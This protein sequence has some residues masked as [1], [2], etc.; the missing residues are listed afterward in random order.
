MSTKQKVLQLLE[1]NR[2]EALS[3]QEMAETLAVSRTSVWKAIEALRQ[4]GYRIEAGPNKGYLLPEETDILSAEAIRLHLDK[5]NSELALRVYK[6]IDS[7]NA[8]AKRILQEGIEQPMLLV[9]EEQTAGRG[10]LGR[11]F[12]SP[13]SSGLYMSLILPRVEPDSDPGLIT[14]AAAVAV[15]RAIEKTTGK[16]PKIKWVN[17]LFLDQRKICG[18]LSEG[19]I[20]FETQTI[21]S[22]IVGI[23]LN[24]RIEEESMPSEL[25]NIVGG[26]YSRE[27]EEEPAVR[28]QLAAQSMNEF[29]ALYPGDG[30]RGY[31]EEY[32]QRCFVLGRKVS[33]TRNGET[34]R[35]EAL[36]IDEQG[37]LI[38][39]LE[40]GEDLTLTYG[41]ISVRVTE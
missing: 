33:F 21:Q 14:T 29:L 7:T 26:I 18:I 35:G 2:G 19:V 11:P 37:G 38:I 23:G 6:S 41:E 4:E 32:R 1:E 39:R 8:E 25:Q 22:I 10:R 28:N 40:N 17:D 31:L 34:M 12:Y 36:S 9:A 24:I 16:S 30:T 5:E 15:C 20:D 3:G 27:E 13:H